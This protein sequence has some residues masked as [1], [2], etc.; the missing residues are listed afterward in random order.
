M[1]CCHERCSLRDAINDT[2]QH[3]PDISDEV[4]DADVDVMRGIEAQIMRLPTTCTADFAAKVIIDSSDGGCLS[5]WETGLLWKEARALT[6]C[7]I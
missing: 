7:S 2:A 1:L 3:D 5:E 4:L 6:G